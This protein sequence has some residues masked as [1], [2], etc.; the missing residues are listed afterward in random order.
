MGF[1]VLSVFKQ[2]D[3][4]YMGNQPTVFYLYGR[5]KE[6]DRWEGQP[7]HA[8]KT[9]AMGRFK[10]AVYSLGLKRRF[11]DYHKIYLYQGRSRLVKCEMKKNDE[12]YRTLEMQFATREAFAEWAACTEAIF[13]SSV[14]LLEPE[15][16]EVYRGMDG[17]PLEW[18][19]MSARPIG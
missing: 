15:Y 9:Q 17:S 5:L 14:G 4:V 19:Y 11:H 16:N 8:F 1:I 2:D 12:G 18:R 6:T 3:M 7:L 13:G 10:H